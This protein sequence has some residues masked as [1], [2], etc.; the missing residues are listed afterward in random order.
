MLIKLSWNRLAAVGGIL[1]LAVVYFVSWRAPSVG[2]YH[3]DG[4]YAVTAKALAE[5]QGYRLIN[6]PHEISQTKYPFL[7]PAALSLIWRLRPDFPGNVMALKA[8]PLLCALGW[9]VL[10][11]KLLLRLGARETQAR[12][13]VLLV[14]ASP[15]V[16]F[17]STNLMSE[18]MFGALL[19]SALLAA[20]AVERSKSDQLAWLAGMLAALAFLTRS[21]GVAVMIAIPLALLFQRRYGAVWRFVAASVPIS[22]TWPLWV[23]LQPVLADRTALYY[24]SANYS[25]WNI[26][27]NY[28]MSEKVGILFTNILLSL[29]APL[30]LLD[31]P[32]RVWLALAMLVVVILAFAKRIPKADS[33]HVSVAVYMCLVL[34]WAWPPARFIAVILPLLLFTIWETFERFGLHQLT[35]IVAGSV[36]CFAVVGDL[37]RVPATISRGQFAFGQGSANDWNELRGV[38]SWVRNNTP[39]DA[40]M[41]ANLDPSTFLYT[42]RKSMRDFI[43]DARKLFYAPGS[44]TDDSLGSLEDVIRSTSASFLIMT[45]DWGFAEAPVLRR[46]LERFKLDHPKQL[47][48]VN[49]PGSNRDYQ[50]YRIRPGEIH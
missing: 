16:I 31:L 45:P 40:V 5:N 10:S 30:T 15:L 13:I 44:P 35:A 14:A 36:F 34:C 32:G 22:C 4:V 43:P 29:A 20:T 33:A 23:S 18:P 3:D 50:I 27:T 24:S 1:L 28:S 25:S 41:L 21:I 17:L 42:G 6:L 9:F 19:I 2:L 38:F 26:L 39:R 7:F 46:N 8:L 47:D 37:R 49:R 11:Y 48:L 12:W